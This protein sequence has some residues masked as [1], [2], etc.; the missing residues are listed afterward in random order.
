MSDLMKKNLRTF[1][2][3]LAPW[4]FVLAAVSAVT[5]MVYRIGRAW[6]GMNKETGNT[7]LDFHTGEWINA[8]FS[9]VYVLLVGGGLLFLLGTGAVLW[10][11]GRTRAGA[12]FWHRVLGVVLMLPLTATVLTGILAKL[13]EEWFGFSENTGKLLMTIHEGRWLGQDGRPFYV[14]FVGLGLLALGIS[15]L[16][17]LL[18][19]RNRPVEA[20]MPPRP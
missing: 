4:I 13:G 2:R 19:K 12:R 15:G 20:G 11:Q 18:P 1:H 8:A 9:P 3:R 17:L 10:W 16:R 5:G 6:F 7:V 14:L